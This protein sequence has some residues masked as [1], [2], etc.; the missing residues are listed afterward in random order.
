MSLSESIREDVAMI[1]PEASRIR[2]YFE[3][4]A[5]KQE[6]SSL[7]HLATSLEHHVKGILGQSDFLTT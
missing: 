3:P 7:R 5:F 2:R 6:L 1:M 4:W